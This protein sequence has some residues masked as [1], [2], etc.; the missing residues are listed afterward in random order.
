MQTTGRS[1]IRLTITGGILALT[2]LTWV[3]T[4]A[5]ETCVG[6]VAG[7]GTGTNGFTVGITNTCEE[8]CP[9]GLDALTGDPAL[10]R[11]L[12]VLLSAQARAVIVTASYHISG[13]RCMVTS[14]SA[15]SAN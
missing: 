10:N 13:A 5:A 12:A 7:L 3:T 8:Q 6:R 1:A 11:M 15:G 4:S 14:T 9:G 2:T